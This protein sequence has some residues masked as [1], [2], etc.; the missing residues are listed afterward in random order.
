M[1]YAEK[2]K[3]HELRVV[4]FESRVVEPYFFERV[5]NYGEVKVGDRK[6]LIAVHKCEDTVVAVTETKFT[7]HFEKL[8]YTNEQVYLSTCLTHNPE[9]L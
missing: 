7:L 1:G 3:F 6:K 5:I 8:G 9:I 4:E 2:E